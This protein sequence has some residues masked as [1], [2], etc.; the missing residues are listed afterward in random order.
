MRSTGN[1]RLQHTGEKFVLFIPDRLNPSAPQGVK[2]REL[3]AV[4]V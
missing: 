2:S 1:N 4:M 3:R